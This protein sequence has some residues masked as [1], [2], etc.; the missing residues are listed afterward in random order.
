MSG[1]ELSGPSSGREEENP[2]APMPGAPSV[3][4]RFVIAGIV[5]A[6]VGMVGCGAW[7][8]LI[9]HRIVSDHVSVV[10]TLKSLSTSEEQFHS[11]AIVD[12]DGDRIGEYG[13]FQELGGTS[14]T[15]ASGDLW[16]PRVNP[17]FLAATFGTTA[18]ANGGVADKS[19]Y[20][21]L[22]FLSGSA[23]PPVRETSPLLAGDA[24]Q[25]NNQETR[26]ACYAWPSSAGTTGN[27]CFAIN[28]EGQVY[29]APNAGPL[30]DGVAA[31]VWTGNEAY[32]NAA[33][34][35]DGPIVCDGMPA[36]DGQV[37]TPVER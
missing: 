2:A 12:C 37:W 4:R 15:R 17:T 34:N 35:L 16:G 20:C 32:A 19:G 36:S 10:G 28:Q 14:G 6:I 3:T 8:F 24:L 7:L 29:Q 18:A 22:I 27:R 33:G 31:P 25:A 9:P 1:R 21:F 23:A 26:W 5:L 11:Q 13:Y 30:Y